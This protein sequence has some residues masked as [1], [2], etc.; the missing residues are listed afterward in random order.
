MIFD[1]VSSK[2]LD[3]MKTLL[4]KQQYHRISNGLL[5]IMGFVLVLMET[6]MDSVGL[7]W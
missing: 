6:V 5:V 2:S 3:G 4:K 1:L 7:C